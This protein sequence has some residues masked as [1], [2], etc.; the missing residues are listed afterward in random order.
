MTRV[1]A[2]GAIVKPK[3]TCRVNNCTK[4]YSSKSYLK[5]HQTKVHQ[6]A[7]NDDNAE[8]DM[9][10]DENIE[11]EIDDELS[12]G[13]QVLINVI[14]NEGRN[15]A[16]EAEVV[17]ADQLIEALETDLDYYS[18]VTH[19]VTGVLFKKRVS[20]CVI[21]VLAEIG[22][23]QV[24][25]K[26]K[27]KEKVSPQCDECVKRKEVA[28]N[29]EELLKKSEKDNK[30]M[31]DKL[32]SMAGQRRFHVSKSKALEK[33]VENTR[34][35]L[36]EMQKR[37]SVLE[38]EKS[39]LEALK[40]LAPLPP[41]LVSDMVGPEAV[42]E[43]ATAAHTEEQVVRSQPKTKGAKKVKCRKCNEEREDMTS[44]IEHMKVKHPSIQYKCDKCPQKYPFMSALS[45]HFRI[46]HPAI[47]HS[48]N[49]C[50]TVFVTKL[51]LDA[52]RSTKCKTPATRVQQHVVASQAPAPHVPAPQ[53]P[54][55]HLPAPQVPAPHVPAP[56]VPAPH[57]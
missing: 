12:G 17:V 55:P 44:L 9:E 7:E 13:T 38:L 46:A 52:H 20:P 6:L 49:V 29:Q 19:M 48:C 36:G 1:C 57:I 23:K 39:T 15:K 26:L 33:E 2:N 10:D 41:Q 42:P 5:K 43:T 14:E 37:I 50:K 3:A 40:N 56:Q 8:A 27:E 28:E 4:E 25:P 47:A 35:T 18:M 21:D 51:G 34:K 16:V 31:V 24:T 45:N 22:G 11:D 30:N 32:K 53:V 54:A